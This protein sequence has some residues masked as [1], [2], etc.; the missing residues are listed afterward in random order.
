MIEVLDRY[1][2]H[3]SAPTPSL[4]SCLNDI[5]RQLW[6][7]FRK[8]AFYLIAS[9]LPNSFGQNICIFAVLLQ[10]STTASICYRGWNQSVKTTSRSNAKQTALLSSNLSFTK[11]RTTR[12]MK[13]WSVLMLSCKVGGRILKSLVWILYLHLCCYWKTKFEFMIISC[14]IFFCEFDNLLWK[15]YIFEFFALFFM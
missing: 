11:L 10:M 4:K 13:L 9:A 5:A 8:T 15:Y 7:F 1:H 6:Y 3:L 12:R 2:Q 14:V